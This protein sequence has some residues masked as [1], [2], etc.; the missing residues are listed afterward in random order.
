MAEAF[1]SP[2]WYRVAGRRLAL[3]PHVAV[4]VHRYRGRIWYVLQ[5]GASRRV[6]RLTPTAMTLLDRLDGRR[7]LDEV[8]TEVAGELED[9]APSQDCLLYTSRCV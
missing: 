7:T 8:W 3:K 6:H 2:S 1:L 9:L 5:D 4:H